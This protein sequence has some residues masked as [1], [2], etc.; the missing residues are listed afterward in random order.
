MARLDYAPD[1]KSTVYGSYTFSDTTNIIPRGYLGDPTKFR[2]LHAGSEVFHVYHLHG[3]ADRWR[4][5]PAADP[6]FDYDKT[7]LDKHPSTIQAESARI[8]SQSMGPGEAFNLEIENGAGGGQQGAGEF[9]FHCHIAHH[10]FAGMWGYWRVYD[11][12]QP[13]LMPL[14][15]RPLMPRPSTRRG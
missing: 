11:T 6:T 1:Q 4:L 12:L 10:Y 8:D 5:N 14:P 13:D 15:D 9:L 7:G 3:G 2:L